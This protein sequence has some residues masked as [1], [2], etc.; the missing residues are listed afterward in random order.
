LIIILIL[1]CGSSPAALTAYGVPPVR[2]PALCIAV[3]S[4]VAPRLDA[5]HPDSTAAGTTLDLPTI[6]VIGSRASLSGIPG[7]GEVIDSANLVNARV[8]TVTEALRKVPGLTVRDEEGFGLRPNIGV[9]GL[10]PTRSSK[11]LLLEDGIPFVIAPYGA[12]ESYYHPPIDRF[13]RVEV[14]KGS[15]QI[16]FGPQTIGGVINYITP[17]VP[18]RPGASVSITPGNRDYFNGRVRAGGTW[19]GAGVLAEYMRKQGDGSREN[20][21]SKLDD[22]SIKTALHLGDRQ[23]LTLRGNYYRE[24]SNVTYS[25]LTE[26]EFAASPYQNPFVND[27][28]LL[29]RWGASATHRFDLSSGAALTTTAYGYQVSRD[30]WRQSSNS[31]QRPND[32]S[33]P[34]CGG[35]A[36]LSSSC[37]N[38]GRLRDYTVYGVEPRLRWSYALG[39]VAAVT[40]VGVRAHYELQ[41]RLQV[42][43][44]T[45]TAREPGPASD[46]NAGLKEDNERTNQAYSAFLQQ[47]FIVGRLGVVPGVRIEHVRYR[48]TN[49]LPAATGGAEIAG[50]TTLTQMIP[51]LGATYQAAAGTTVFAGVHRGFSPPRTEDV[52]D[53]ATGGVV[54]L[55]AELSWNYEVGVRSDLA[56]GLRVE[57]TA[58][59]MDFQNQ[60]IAANL[61]GGAGSALTSAGETTHRG[62][63]LAARYS[64][65]P[66]LPLGHDIYVQAAYTWLPVAEFGGSRFVFVGTADGDE[67]GKIFTAQNPTG[68]RAQV[69]VSGKRLPY[70]PEHLL[71][72]TVGY[73]HRSGLDVRLEGVHVGGQFGDALNTSILSADG[74]QGPI[75][76]FTIWNAAASFRIGLTHSTVFV[77]VKNLFDKLYIAD[78]SRGLIPGGPRL[79]QAGVTQV[80]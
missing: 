18:S 1:N 21:G 12:N 38:E 54:D 20:L 76:A 27:S 23:T 70:A 72:G 75:P 64:A 69:S 28:M 10:N 60:I 7:S 16:L 78:R 2:L 33:D 17:A 55:D 43:G 26:G 4:L 59:A 15:G 65:A 58:F 29:D 36:N 49:L 31:G 25:G 14:L 53:N 3:C 71:T 8:F 5:Q 24:R 37:G 50:R 46:V 61:A 67:V 42:N 30:W 56:R 13:A 62:V 79:V 22:A 77:A 51:G 9:R 47:R 73:G 41:E 40:D 52:I 32:R 19:G 44:A 57:A 35:I 80:F 74:Q 45:P 6:E 48:R 68:S 66:W 11:V 34:A 39:N 63:E